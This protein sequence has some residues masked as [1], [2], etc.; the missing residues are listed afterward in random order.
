MHISIYKNKQMTT[1]Q[2]SELSESETKW[3]TDADIDKEYEINKQFSQS[4]FNLQFSVL[5]CIFSLSSW[6]QC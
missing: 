4:D 6:P 1:H 5:H 2:A 3:L